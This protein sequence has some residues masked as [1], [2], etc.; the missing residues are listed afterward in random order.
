MFNEA[1]LSIWQSLSDWPWPGATDK[2]RVSEPRQKAI[3]EIP[4]G[5][6]DVTAILVVTIE[7]QG[8]I[9]ESDVS[10]AA[11]QLSPRAHI[12]S[13]KVKSAC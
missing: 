12:P 1:T 9:A 5:M 13:S 3:M 7:V 4:S 11:P 6:R 8:P 2:D 10:D